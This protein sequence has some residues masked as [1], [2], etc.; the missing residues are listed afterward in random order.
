MVRQYAR[1]QLAHQGPFNC[2][3]PPPTAAA[4][5]RSELFLLSLGMNLV[6][7]TVAL[8]PDSRWRATSSDKSFTMAP[9]AM[10]RTLATRLSLHLALALA[11]IQQR[12]LPR[13]SL[14]LKTR[15]STE[16]KISLPMPSLHSSSWLASMIRT[17]LPKRDPLLIPHTNLLME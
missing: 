16:E 10:I 9:N 3:S 6:M 17:P 5:S 2:S 13:R 15:L 12:D 7:L 4:I 8:V 11:M 1:L 14:R